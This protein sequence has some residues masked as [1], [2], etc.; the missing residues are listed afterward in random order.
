MRGLLA[1]SVVARRTRLA[2][3]LW[4]AVA[5]AGCDDGVRSD[6]A[7]IASVQLLPAPPTLFVGSQL[8]LTAVP[9]SSAG[10]SLPGGNTTWTS[11]VPTVATV[12][13]S[14]LVA[15]VGVGTTTISA[16]VAGRTGQATVRVQ[17]ATV[18]A[19]DFNPAT[20]AVEPGRSWQVTATARSPSGATVYDWPRQWSSSDTAVAVVAGDGLVTGRA[21]GTAVL[22]VRVADTTVAYGVTVS[23]AKDN[24]RLVSLTMVQASNSVPGVAPIIAG[25]AVL[26]RAAVTAAAV[27]T[28]NRLPVVLEIR[29]RGALEQTLRS[30]AALPWATATQAGAIQ[31][32]ANFTLPATFDWSGV[33]LRAR[34][35]PDGALAEWDEFDNY[36]PYTSE[37]VPD[38]AY[39][40]PLVIHLVPVTSIAEGTSGGISTADETTFLALLRD[41][42]PVLDV[43]LLRRATFVVDGPVGTP[44]GQTA[45]L[46]QLDAA[47]AASGAAGHYFGAFHTVGAFAYAGLGYR[48]GYSAIGLDGLP[49]AANTVAH[50]IGHNLNLQHAPCGTATQVDPFFPYANGAIGVPGYDARHDAIVAATTPDLMSYCFVGTYTQWIS[51]YNYRKALAFRRGV[52]LL[53][54]A[55]PAGPGILV[56]GRIGGDGRIA[57]EP[58]FDLDRA[59]PEAVDGGRATVDGFDASGVRLFS[60]PIALRDVVD[61]APETHFAAAVP[62][63][64][65]LRARLA[66]VTVSTGTAQASLL[67]QAGAALREAP[68][69]RAEPG[70]DGTTLRWNPT[71]AAR[72]MLRDPVSGDVVGFGRGGAMRLPATMHAVDVQFSDGLGT[73]TARHIA[74]GP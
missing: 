5:V 51:D 7:A 27:T 2:A 30:N 25:R 71:A 47:R 50:E 15:A 53:R 54:D 8:L 67:G 20:L 65:A 9:R 42:L 11:S 57:L 23:S 21:P 4:L 69:L 26:L 45:L 48:P 35:D 10:D 17:H 6:P 44:E 22:S 73:F 58:L 49:W 63:A 18:A 68:V 43:T 70:A 41:A 61:G 64:L 24:L 55:A 60:Q 3:G 19:I 62:L 31:S 36:W 32:T 40:P 72:V 12:S 66:R 37:L 14:G 74:L 28:G 33:T 13:A 56:W 38:V 16:T 1:P 52:T 46:A 39:L 59:L 29:R 34:V